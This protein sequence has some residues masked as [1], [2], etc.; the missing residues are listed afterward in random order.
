VK[1]EVEIPLSAERQLEGFLKKSI[2]QSLEYVPTQRA[3][4]LSLSA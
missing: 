2:A 1:E 4:A 3:R